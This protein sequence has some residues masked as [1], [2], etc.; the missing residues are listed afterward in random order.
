MR[1]L[2]FGQIKNL[3]KLHMCGPKGNL[4]L[5]P[6]RVSLKSMPI[7]LLPYYP[8]PQMKQLRLRNFK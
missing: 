4:G 6:G 1:K 7:T 2:R 3:F 5:D 8:R